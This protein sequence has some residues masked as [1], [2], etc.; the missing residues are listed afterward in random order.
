MAMFTAEELEELKRF[1]EEIDKADL[2]Y[3]DYLI[4]DLVEDLLFPEKAR[5]RER[6]AESYKRQ[7]ASKDPEKLK[8]KRK[9]DYAVKDKEAER[10][11]K[12]EWYRK[13]K[14]RIRLQQ[15]DYRVRTG[16][17]KAV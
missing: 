11:R 16:R 5:E 14:E 10:R 1:D 7:M 4:E 12:Q 6:K 9:A 17:Q 15:K 13:N 2:T 3:E 8:A